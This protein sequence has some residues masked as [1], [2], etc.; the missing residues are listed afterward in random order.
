MAPSLLWTPYQ[1][2][3]S[4]TSNVW[5]L[6]SA[7]NVAI[8]CVEVRRTCRIS[9]VSFRENIIY[10]KI[11]VLH[12]SFSVILVFTK[13]S[14]CTANASHS[15]IVADRLIVA[16]TTVVF[17]VEEL[18][19]AHQMPPSVN[20]SLDEIDLTAL[21]VRMSWKLRVIYH[22]RLWVSPALKGSR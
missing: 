1:L 8:H 19:M 7:G 6:R 3:C 22:G 21:K 12:I 13:S 4:L 2:P 9:C 14:A 10:R 16:F 20:C 11:C 15:L 17:S 5:H 18:K